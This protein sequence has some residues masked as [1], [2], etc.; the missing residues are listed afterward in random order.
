MTVK[1]PDMKIAL[2]K[3]KGAA[4]RSMHPLIKQSADMCAELSLSKMQGQSHT[5]GFL[6]PAISNDTAANMLPPIGR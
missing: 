5:V 6:R 3:R 2:S 4:V 1:A